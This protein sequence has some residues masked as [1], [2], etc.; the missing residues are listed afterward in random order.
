M[1]YQAMP[2][3]TITRVGVLGIWV[4][5]HKRIEKSPNGELARRLRGVAR[6]G[7]VVGYLAFG[8]DLLLLSSFVDFMS[9]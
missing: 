4:R 6:K 2:E 1:M 9:L 5:S 8:S 7:G 3:L